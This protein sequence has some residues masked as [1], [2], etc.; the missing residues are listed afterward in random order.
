MNLQDVTSTPLY[1]DGWYFAPNDSGDVVQYKVSTKETIYPTLK[2]GTSYALP[3]ASLA[4]KIVLAADCDFKFEG[5][6]G[7]EVDFWAGDISA[8]F[9]LG[10][11]YEYREMLRISF[12][13]DRQEPSAGIGLSA[14]PFGLD[15]AF[16]RDAEIDNT[17][18]ISVSMD[19]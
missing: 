2:V 1:W 19:F 10:A 3:V 15:Y 9:R 13:M 5:L 8:D 14:G 12:G 17:H 7:E 11:M 18:R 4:G 6:K 16:W